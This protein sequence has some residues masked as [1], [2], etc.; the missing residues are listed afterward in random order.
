MGHSRQALLHASALK[1]LVGRFTPEEARSLHADARAK[2]LSMIREHAGAY[3]REA[4]AL[5]TQLAPVFGSH[6]GDGQAPGLEAPAQAAE[7]LLRSSYAQD[8][9]VRAAFTLSEGGSAAAIKSRQFWG[10]LAS[11][12]R[13]AAAIQEAYDR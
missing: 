9:A 2:W 11:S 4:A 1:R 6:G 8:D 7:R 5:R 13:L 10:A 12:E 3:R